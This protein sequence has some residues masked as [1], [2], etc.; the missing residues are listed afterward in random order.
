MQVWSKNRNRGQMHLKLI[1]QADEL[2]FLAG[3]L[4]SVAFLTKIQNN[5]FSNLSMFAASSRLNQNL[6]SNKKFYMQVCCKPLN[7]LHSLLNI[8]V[9]IR[10]KVR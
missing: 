5:L 8:F 7:I 4:K 6:I 3:L 1:L 2:Q 9:S 10:Y